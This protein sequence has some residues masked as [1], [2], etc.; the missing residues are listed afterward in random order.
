MIV[1]HC[2]S[3]LQVV[4]SGEAWR[5]NDAV[6]LL[7]FVSKNV[8]T[9]AHRCRTS[10]FFKLSFSRQVVLSGIFLAAALGD[11]TL[12]SKLQQT[13]FSAILHFFRN[14]RRFATACGPFINP[15]QCSPW[16]RSQNAYNCSHYESKGS[17][18]YAGRRAIR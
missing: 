17:T 16:L 18:P 15:C 10:P 9:S 1:A 6:C 4:R 13:T 7:S 14:W 8:C 11:E 12:G 3:R 5:L 2:V